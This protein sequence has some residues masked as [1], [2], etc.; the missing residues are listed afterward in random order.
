MPPLV[1]GTLMVVGPLISGLVLA[2]VI[3]V[4]KLLSEFRQWITRMEEFEKVVKE[5]LKENRMAHVVLRKELSEHANNEVAIMR[6]L[7][8]KVMAQ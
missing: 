7:Q 2:M 1:H 8:R 6:E 3:G 5:E 4:F